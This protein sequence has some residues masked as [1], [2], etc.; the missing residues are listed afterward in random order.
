MPVTRGVQWDMMETF[1]TRFVVD[2]TT[3]KY[4]LDTSFCMSVPYSTCASK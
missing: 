1:V 2:E 4:V 3:S